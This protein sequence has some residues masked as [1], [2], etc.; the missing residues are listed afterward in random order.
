MNSPLGWW[1]AWRGAQHGKDE[2]LRYF[3]TFMERFPI[4][5]GDERSLL[6]AESHVEILENTARGKHAAQRA[7]RDWLTITWE[8][9]RPPG[10]LTDPF[11]LSVDAFA[12]ALRAA[13]PARRRNLSA[14]AVAAI[15]AEYAETVAPVAAR[16][17]EVSRLENELSCLVNRAYGLTQEDEHLMWAT[18]PPRMPIAPPSG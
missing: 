9:T 2:A 7:L 14:A 13:L 10:I 16:L 8:M 1:F 12:Q 3:S 6:I 15:R 5:R 11:A 17:A 18:A 4:A